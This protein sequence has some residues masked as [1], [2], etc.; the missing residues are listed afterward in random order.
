MCSKLDHPYSAF[1]PHFL[2]AAMFPARLKSSA[3]SRRD[4]GHLIEPRFAR[5]QIE[6]GI[7]GDASERVGHEGRPVHQRGSRIVGP[8]GL[9]NFAAGDG[10][11]KRQCAAGQGFRQGEDIRN[12]AGLLEGEH[13]TGAAKASEDFIEDQQY[14]VALRSRPQSL[15]N[16]SI[17]KAH[18]AGALHQGFDDDCSHLAG[19]VGEHGLERRRGRLIHRQIDDDL[20]GQ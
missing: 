4:L 19:A 11:G 1:D 9:E 17:V 3:K 12:D 8:E 7:R 18:A 15:E 2:H 5:K 13:R 14:L 10:C 20:L 16:T 6:R